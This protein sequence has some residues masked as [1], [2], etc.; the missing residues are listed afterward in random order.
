MERS[1]TNLLPA[2]EIIH[3]TYTNDHFTLRQNC[4]KEYYKGKV[5]TEPDVIRVNK[6]WGNRLWQGYV[7]VECKSEPIVCAMILRS[8]MPRQRIQVKGN[9]LR[10]PKAMI[11]DII[12]LLEPKIKP[13]RELGISFDS[14]TEES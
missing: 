2:A 11:K 4:V 5:H 1:V 3:Y 7:L 13:T 6:S 14:E 10:L 9:E 8:L 12:G